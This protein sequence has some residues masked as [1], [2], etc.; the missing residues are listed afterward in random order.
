MVT[1]FEDKTRVKIGKLWIGG[2]G[3]M[4]IWI[5]HNI[6]VGQTFWRLKRKQLKCPRLIW[7][8]RKS[9]ERFLL[10]SA[11]HCFILSILDLIRL[12]GKGVA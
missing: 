7:G 12:I 4:E 10:F 1:K 9:T 8:V 3:E 2:S 11:P 6:L 5:A